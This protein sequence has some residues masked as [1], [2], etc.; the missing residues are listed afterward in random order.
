MSARVSAD[1][2]EEIRRS[3]DA[4]FARPL[5]QVEGSFEDLIAIRVANDQFALRLSELA[6]IH[7]WSRITALPGS[8]PALLGLSGIRGRVTAIYELARVLGYERE[9]AAPRWIALC[10][11]DAPIGIA[12]GEI[13]GYIRLG[14]SEL[15]A[16]RRDERRLAYVDEAFERDSVVRGVLGMPA[17]VAALRGSVSPAGGPHRP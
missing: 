14:R 11:A 6:G 13:D 15:R 12:I 8:Q 3:F 7:A 5:E 16:I 4:S 10:R 2:V 1:R 17:L 9:E